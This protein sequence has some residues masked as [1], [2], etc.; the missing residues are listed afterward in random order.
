V[1][2]VDRRIGSSLVLVNKLGGLV[3]IFKGK[4]V[5]DAM[6]EYSGLRIYVKDENDVVERDIDFVEAD[7]IASN[8]PDSI[9][10]EL[11]EVEMKKQDNDP[12]G[13]VCTVCGM[14]YMPPQS[15]VGAARLLD[16]RE[17]LLKYVEGDREALDAETALYAEMALGM[18]EIMLTR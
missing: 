12:T 4:E 14:V 16:A 6:L 1:A 11:D 15:R 2:V 13:S 3:K 17:K 10:A 18:Y 8:S 9:W 7:E 5:T